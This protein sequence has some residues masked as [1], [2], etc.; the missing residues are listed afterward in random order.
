MKTQPCIGSDKQKSKTRMNKKSRPNLK[1]ESKKV[2][3]FC[4]YFWHF[5]ICKLS[6]PRCH[7]QFWLFSENHG[8]I[9]SYGTH[10]NRLYLSLYRLWHNCSWQRKE[11]LIFF[12]NTWVLQIISSDRLLFHTA[13]S[14]LWGCSLLCHRWSH[15]HSLAR[16]YTTGESTGTGHIY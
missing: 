1:R 7:F 14:P 5:S 9:R 6:L 10:M 16:F 3:V 13:P 11:M 2:N 8:T 4:M 15:Q 12:N